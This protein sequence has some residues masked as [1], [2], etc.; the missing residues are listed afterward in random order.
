MDLREFFDA[1]GIHYTS[2][3]SGVMAKLPKYTGY[4]FWEKWEDNLIPDLKK[5]RKPV[6]VDDFSY[7]MKA[8]QVDPRNWVAVEEE[9]V[10]AFSDKAIANIF[11]GSSATYW[12]S[13]G[14]TRPYYNI[15]PQIV[16]DMQSTHRINYVELQ[17]YNTGYYRQNCWKFRVDVKDYYGDDYQTVGE[18][19]TAQ[20]KDIQRFDLDR[21]YA[22]QFIRITF[23]EGIHEGGNTNGSIMVAEFKVGKSEE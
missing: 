9:C 19:E 2:R 17:H 12:A 22:A 21:D 3:A 13:E 4:K 1:W 11:D 14:V 23:L 5:E 16:I 18:F 8:G 6:K 7:G 20:N 10:H 15:L